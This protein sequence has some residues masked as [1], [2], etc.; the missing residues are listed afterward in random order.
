MTLKDAEQMTLRILSQVMEESP[1]S[2]NTEVA[3][4]SEGKYKLLEQEEVGELLR[5]LKPQ[6]STTT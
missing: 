3:I 2:T 6:V 4:V 1:T 5:A